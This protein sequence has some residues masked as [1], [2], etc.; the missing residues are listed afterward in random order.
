M[1]KGTSVSW[2]ANERA[3]VGV[4]VVDQDGDNILVAQSVGDSIMRPV[5]LLPVGILTIVP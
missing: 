4:T 3:C 5:Y 1:T 2:T